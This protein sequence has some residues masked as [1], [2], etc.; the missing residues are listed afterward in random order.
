M[1]ATAPAR[2]GAGPGNIALYVTEG[3]F[4]FAGVLDVGRQVIGR[5]AETLGTAL[6]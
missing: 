2:A 5:A 3:C 6:S 4:Q 1:P